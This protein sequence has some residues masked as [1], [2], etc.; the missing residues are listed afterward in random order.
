MYKAGIKRPSHFGVQYLTTITDCMAGLGAAKQNTA[1]HTQLLIMKKFFSFLILAFG[2]TA[3]LYSCHPDSK[4]E[5]IV[6]PA[7]TAPVIIEKAP[8]QK[9]TTITLDKNGVKIEAKKIDVTLK[10]Q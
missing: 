10:K 6:V 9:A 2:F 3:V 7:T 4:K 1:F 8:V 5:V